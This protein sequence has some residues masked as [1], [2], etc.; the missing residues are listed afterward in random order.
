MIITLS[1]E[2]K[3]KKFDKEKLYVH[4]S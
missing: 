2:W 3:S 4:M 1:Y